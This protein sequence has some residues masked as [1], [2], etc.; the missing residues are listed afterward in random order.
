GVVAAGGDSGLSLAPLSPGAVFDN[1]AAVR[2]FG[3]AAAGVALFGAF[4]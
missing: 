3:A 1:D 2:T 4:W